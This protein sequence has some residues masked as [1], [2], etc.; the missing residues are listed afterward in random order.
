M[1]AAGVIQHVVLMGL[2]VTAD[3]EVWKGV[4]LVVA[5]HIVN[6]YR[7][8]DLV[9]SAPRCQHDVWRRRAR[10]RSAATASRTTT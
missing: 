1:R 3:P 7:P 8:N 5:G 10:R 4:R 2:P 6:C 9:D